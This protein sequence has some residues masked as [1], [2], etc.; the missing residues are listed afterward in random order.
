MKICS[1]SECERKHY[2]KS[3]CTKHYARLKSNL[4]PIIRTK[5]DK[6]QIIVNFNYAEI[7]LFD[8][9]NKES[10]RTKVDIDQ[11]DNVKQY[12]WHLNSGGYVVSTSNKRKQ[13]SLHRFIMAYEGDETIDHINRDPLDNRK[14]NLRIA[15]R[16]QNCQNKDTKGYFYSEKRKKWITVVRYRGRKVLYKYLNTEQE[17]IKA[18]KVAREKHFGEFAPR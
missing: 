10:A 3:F 14:A 6:N 8:I 11:I 1:V 5:F 9:K 16:W 17:A 13:I 15:T 4:D 12:K 2:A 18:V 7:I